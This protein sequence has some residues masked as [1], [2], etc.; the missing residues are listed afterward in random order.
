MGE[1]STHASSAADQL[2]NAAYSSHYCSW[3]RNIR[4]TSE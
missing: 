2:K 3:D 1:V 4:T